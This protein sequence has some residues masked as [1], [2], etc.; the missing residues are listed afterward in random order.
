VADHL[1]DACGADLLVGSSLAGQ[2]GDLL[3]LRSQVGAGIFAALAHLLTGRLELS[4]RAFGEGLDAH[5]R[6]R[7]ERGPQLV[8]GIDPPLLPAQPFAVDQVGAG[9][10]GRHPGSAQQFDRLAV[11]LFGRAAPDTSAR[12]RAAAPRAQLLELATASC[13]S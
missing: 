1:K 6:E 4:P 3:L 12:D 10:V 7:V 2:L 9:Q 8:A 5:G 11:L 13:D